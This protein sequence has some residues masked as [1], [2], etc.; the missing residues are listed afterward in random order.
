[1][2]EDPVD[3]SFRAPTSAL[4]GFDIELINLALAYVYGASDFVFAAVER[5]RAHDVIFHSPTGP[6]A[7]AGIVYASL[8]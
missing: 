5:Q 6:V 2:L 7:R 8:L 4:K 3:V 1:M